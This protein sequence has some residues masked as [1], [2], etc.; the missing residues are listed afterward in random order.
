M[1]SLERGAEV[2][3]LDTLDLQRAFAVKISK[4]GRESIVS[5]VHSRYSCTPDDLVLHTKAVHQ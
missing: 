4:A 2:L 5:I 1:R 3:G